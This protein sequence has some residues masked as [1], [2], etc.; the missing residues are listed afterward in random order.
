ME[1]DT[2]KEF[3][4]RYDLF[5]DNKDESDPLRRQFFSRIFEEYK[6]RSVLDCACGTGRDLIL[7]KSLGCQVLGSDISDSM[8]AQA[9]NNFSDRGMQITLVKADYRELPDH[10]SS[11]FDAIVCLSTAISEMQNET[12]V[13]NA[14]GS[15][16][17]V[18]NEGGI[19]VM[20]QGTTDK[21]M[22]DKPRFLPMVNNPDFSR[23][24]VI[25]YF[26][27]GARYNI[28]DIF[29]DKDNFDF[30][31][32]SIDYKQILLKDDFDKLLKTTGFKKID[33]YADFNLEPY[34]KKSSNRLITIA[35]K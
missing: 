29:H 11:K 20:T 25:D 5:F 12:E 17:Q 15:M 8:L 32:W 35:K 21:Q 30:K 7:F 3:A 27:K 1:N 33:F 31:I 19:L 28:L 22:K 2:Y 9:R 23:I 18:L 26:K 6:V 10:F 16:Y 14:F 34:D 13:L 24:S 4:D